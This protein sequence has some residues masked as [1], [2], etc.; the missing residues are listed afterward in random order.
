MKNTFLLSFLL[1]LAACDRARDAAAGTEAASAPATFWC[2]PVGACYSQEDACGAG[3]APASEATCYRQVRRGRERAEIHC[4]QMFD[5][6]TSHRAVALGAPA[7]N[8]LAVEGCVTTSGKMDESGDPALVK[9]AAGV[10]AV[11]PEVSKASA[12]LVR[13]RDVVDR[14]CACDDQPC[15]Q[16]VAEEHEKWKS[17]NGWA[18]ESWETDE[19]RGLTAKMTGCIEGA[20]ATKGA[21]TYVESRDQMTDAATRVARTTSTNSHDFGFP[22]EGGTEA[23]LM[24]RQH[25]RKGTDVLVSITQ[26]QI[27][28]HSFMR[29]RINVRFDDA[30]AEKFRGV[31]PADH[32]TTLVFLEPSKS[33][34]KRVKKA[35]RV[36]IEMD[37]YQEGSRVFTFDTEGLEGW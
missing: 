19:V 34:I 32:S 36:A 26:G 8:T 10:P 13:M 14:L 29:C 12:S 5:G 1:C 31:E 35:K 28:C 25:P 4:F 21:W 15:V 33:F 20:T 2:D 23:V 18:F 22:Y 17:K 11:A 16:D 7:E 6:C 9:T 3:C 37:F 27:I 30:P 24:L